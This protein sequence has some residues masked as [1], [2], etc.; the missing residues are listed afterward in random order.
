M[1]IDE[2]EL[3]LPDDELQLHLVEHVATLGLA[4]PQLL[5]FEFSGEILEAGRIALVLHHDAAGAEEQHHD[6]HYE[7][8]EVAFDRHGLSVCGV[9][10]K[11][12]PAGGPRRIP[13]PLIPAFSRREKVRSLMSGGWHFMSAIS[14]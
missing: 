1:E 10:E 3:A 14:D 7:T 8:E 6:Q 9:V 13:Y 5:D 11:T 4:V 2:D 12:G